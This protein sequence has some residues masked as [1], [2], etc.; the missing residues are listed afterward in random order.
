MTDIGLQRI[1]PSEDAKRHCGLHRLQDLFAP[2]FIWQAFQRKF[3]I[4][5]AVVLKIIHQ[6]F[7]APSRPD[8]Y[9]QIHRA[10]LDFKLRP[11]VVTLENLFR[12]LSTLVSRG[13]THNTHQVRIRWALASERLTS[14]RHARIAL[15]LAAI[16]LVAFGAAQSASAQNCLRIQIVD[17]SGAAVPNATV[18]IGNSSQPTDDSGIA[19]FCQL[20]E[21]PHEVSVSAPNLQNAS[22][23]TS[24]SAGLMTISLQLEI[25]A[26][27]V[28][29][30]GSRIEGR[31]PLESPVPVELVLGERLRNSG[32]VETGRALQMLSPS[33]NFQSSA[34]TDGT[35]SVRPA[36]L[37]GLGPDQVLVLV[38]GKRR[39]NSALLHVLDTVGRGTAGTDMN[40]IPLS[41]IERIEVLRD[42]AS[43]QYGSDAI[44]GV[45]NLVLKEAPG[46]T[47]DT[48]WGQTYR[49]D[50]DVFTHS[51]NGGWVNEDGAFLNVT[52]EF[53]DREHTNRAGAWGW[54]FY[55]PAECG[56][57]EQPSSTGFCL[58]PRESTVNRHVIRLGDADSRHHSAYF[59]ASA[60][61]G[62]RINFYSFGGFS[63]RDNSSPGFYRVPF[64][65]NPRIV[66]EIHPEGFLPFINTDVQDVSFAAGIDWE[67]ISGWSFDLSVNHGR[68]TFDFLISNSN[69]ASY[70]VD[71]PTEADAGGLKFDQ[72]T[73]N[74]DV[75]RMFEGTEMTTNLALGAEF[76]RDGYGIRAGAPVSYL[77]CLDDPS[78]NKSNCRAGAPP[79]IQVFP[80]YRPTDEVDASRTNT[81]A[82]VDIEWVFGGKFTL[83]TA[84]RFERYSDFGS[85]INGKISARYEVTP[86]FS[87]RGGVNT[88]FRA[89]SLHQLHYSKID[90]LSVESPEG[91]SVL[92]EVGTFPNNSSIV[93]ALDVPPLKQETSVNF[94]GGAVAKFGQTAALTVDAFRVNVDDRIVMSANF[95]ADAVESTAP[96]VALVMRETRIQGAQ[97]FANAARTATSGVE[98]TFNSVHSIRGGAVLDWGVSGAYFDTV[99][100]GELNF[101]SS[102]APIASVLFEPADRAIIEDFQPSTRLQGTAE[103][104]RGRVRFGGGLR[105]FGSY[106]LW[107]Q[108]GL[109]ARSQNQTFTPKTVTDVHFAVR[110]FEG[111]EL[112]VG[113]NNLFDVYPDRNEFNDLFGSFL[114]DLS[115]AP[116]S[117]FTDRNGAVIPG[118]ESHGIFPYARTAPFG[119]NGGYYYTR[120]SFRF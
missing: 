84:G 113:A 105:Y 103:Y 93:Q 76:R 61:L 58:D 70:G 92:A 117:N 30:V 60:P 106:T 31:E 22:R 6:A 29:V 10:S 65:F 17:P 118:T 69:N 51:M 47:M 86:S 34:I 63:T 33:F 104:R 110:L 56:A 79:G 23:I 116:F 85:T 107:D 32:H 49:G 13:S 55:N 119:I 16:L 28:K 83:G 24:Q 48:S 89:P 43:A 99:L 12:Y 71:S 100:E 59:N 3:L 18:A 78:S 88:G 35:D 95:T 36:T 102:L 42:G 98:F 45:I 94:S 108:L 26:E 57:D 8:S 101:P 66:Y 68:N 39:H 62:E 87:L 27:D 1:K 90:T 25:V 2:Q 114:S 96:S 15:R 97:F 37:R 53:R 11:L 81:A 21:G 44:A 82:Y 67:T 91:D 120:L 112:M 4:G 73:F 14:L 41:A 9:S 75:A 115:G 77:H 19:N 64:I 74:F 52:Y 7:L 40:A 38:N 54:P 80:G 20:G 72:T 111:A 46:F 50:G 109:V 5:V